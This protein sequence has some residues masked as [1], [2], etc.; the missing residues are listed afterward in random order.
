MKWSLALGLV[1]GMFGLAAARA[2]EPRRPSVIVVLAD[3]LGYADL[4]FQGGKD[5]PT[6]CLKAGPRRRT[7]R[8]SAGY[9]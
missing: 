8:G 9:R 5:I 7:P 3:D 6:G 1:L 2:A 4:G